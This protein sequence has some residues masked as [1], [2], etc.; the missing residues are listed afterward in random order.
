[1][2][3]LVLAR[4]GD[5]AQAQK[6]ADDLD[7]AFPLDT[8]IQ[9]YWLPTIRGAVALHSGDP[10]RAIE[11]LKAANS[12]ELGQPTLATVFLCPAYVR[13]EAY[14]ALHDGPAAAAEFQKFLD[15]RGLV[16]NFPWAALARLGVARAY[17]L[18]AA[19]DPAAREKALAAYRDFLA[20]W[21][22]A[23]SDIPIYQQAKAEYAKLQ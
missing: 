6:L 22:D 13:G 5:V 19:K 3:A 9:R 23:D 14:L 1:M 8:L 15:H 2:A 4:A 7:K 18:D 21:K 12:I 11:Q 20:L 10:S 17:A 16:V